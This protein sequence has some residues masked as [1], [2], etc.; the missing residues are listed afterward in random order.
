MLPVSWSFTFPLFLLSHFASTRTIHKHGQT[1]QILR[2]MTCDDQFA[3][4][5]WDVFQHETVKSFT[6]IAT[7]D[8]LRDIKR[9]FLRRS[10]CLPCSK[11]FDS[12]E[13]EERMKKLWQRVYCSGCKTEH[14]ELLFRQGD[15][16]SNICVGLQG[17]FALCKHI[18]VSGKVKVHDG[19]Y[20][21]LACTHTEH[22]EQLPNFKRYRP[23]I[24]SFRSLGGVS[25]EY[26]RS[27]PLV[28]IAPEQYPGMPALKS[29]LLK[30][31]KETHYD[32]LCHHSS[33]QLESIVSSLPSDKCDC[34]PAEGLPVRQPEP[35]TLRYYWCKN[36]GYDCR[37]CGAHYLWYYDNNCVVL[38][39]Q[40]PFGNSNVYNIGWLSNITFHSDDYTTHPILNENTKGILWCTDPSC[41][42]GCGNRWLLM[43]EILERLSLRQPGVYKSLPPRDRSSAAN[44]PYT[45][46]YQVFQNAA[47]W[48]TRPDMLSLELLFPRATKFV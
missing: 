19:E 21:K 40:I 35:I 48:L 41:G 4:F 16:G 10:L 6:T 24:L 31:L 7:C 47:G 14:P 17:E 27:F 43:V 15:R 33:T 37:H 12:G 13:L 18:K 28:K 22:F 39:V 45:L 36:H 42:T 32:G 38:R 9:I 23:F 29:R 8:Q 46:E 25:S 3:D 44:L 11:L 1:C 34:F 26:S 2:N 30:Q 20:H 5:R